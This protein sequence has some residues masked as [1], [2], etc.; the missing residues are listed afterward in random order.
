MIR[1]R[2]CLRCGIEFTP[3]SPASKHCTAKCRLLSKIDVRDGA[4]CWGWTGAVFADSGLPLFTVGKKTE[5]TLRPTN[6]QR[7]AFEILVGP[8]PP[9][10]VVV[11]RCRNKLCVRPDHHFLG[12]QSDAERLKPTHTG[13]SRA[14]NGRD[15][16]FKPT[17]TL[18]KRFAEKVDR[19]G[20][21]ECWPWTG[22]MFP[23]PPRTDRLP[24][25]Q[26]GVKRGAKSSSWAPVGAHRV[27]WEL[28][29]GPIPPGLFVC[30]R[31]DNPPCVNVA[32]LFLGTPRENMED[33]C[34]KGRARNGRTGPLPTAAHRP[35]ESPSAVA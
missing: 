9:G 5:G 23:K 4:G 28:A 32:H 2:S 16:R 7:A 31:C 27:A 10:Q 14:R 34:R 24:Y 13:V 19:R 30:H 8:V 1:P 20:P 15:T 25:G 29:N 26:F 11:S 33:K 22:R 21:E 6:G 35:H 3:I 17:K 18:A 12:T